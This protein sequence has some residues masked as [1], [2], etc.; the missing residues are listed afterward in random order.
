MARRSSRRPGESHQG[1]EGWFSRPRK[2]PLAKKGAVAI[3]ADVTAILAHLGE[4]LHA[5]RRGDRATAAHRGDAGGRP[6]GVDSVARRPWLNTGIS[7]ELAGQKSC[8]S[9]SRRSKANYLHRRDLTVIGFWRTGYEDELGRRVLIHEPRTRSRHD[10][11]RWHAAPQTPAPVKGAGKPISHVVRGRCG[12]F[13]FARGAELPH[14][15]QSDRALRTIR[16][17]EADTV[18]SVLPSA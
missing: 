6:Q 1:L 10:R 5:G 15:R 16:R 11:W 8:S 14:A 18:L 13:R 3:S 9:A 12:R 2:S 7:A 4:L 17:R